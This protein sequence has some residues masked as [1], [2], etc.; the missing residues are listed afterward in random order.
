MLSRCFLFFDLYYNPTMWQ[1]SEKRNILVSWFSW[2]Y[3][4]SLSGIYST[5]RNILRFNLDYFSIP[6]LLETLLSPWRKYKIS[7]GKGFD[8]GRF[9]E[10]IA[11]NVFSRIM[12]FLVRVIVIFT[13]VITEVLLLVFGIFVLLF[14]ITLPLITFVGLLLSLQWLILN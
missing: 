8:I 4:I 9:F 7:Y 2:H 1:T 13:G 5:W 3:L 12:G 14:W 6:F 11:F 10:T